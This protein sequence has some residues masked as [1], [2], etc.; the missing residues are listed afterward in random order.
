MVSATMCFGKGHPWR[1]RKT[2]GSPSSARARS[3][4]KPPST[5]VSST[6]G[7][8]LRTR[9]GRRAPAAVGP[10][11]PLQPLR[12]ER[13]AAGP[14]GA[15]LPTTPST[16]SPATRIASPAGSTS[17][18]IWSRS[19]RARRCRDCIRTET[20]IVLQSAGAACSRTTRRATASAAS[21]LSVSCSA[22]EGQGTHRGG[23]HRPRL[24]RHLRPAPLAGRRRHP[25]GGRARRRAAH[26]LSA[27]TTS[28]ATRK[29]HYAGKNV[30]VVGGG[31]SA[32][33]T[34]C[35]LADAGRAARRHLGHLA[36]PHTRHAADQRIAERPA[37]R[38]RPPGRAG[39]HAR[40]PRR[41]QRRVPRARPSS[42][43]SSR[44]A[45][46][47][48][49][50]STPACRQEPADLGG[51]PRHRQRRLHAG[52][53]PL[54]RAASPRM[55]RVARPDEAGGRRCSSTPATTA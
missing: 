9:P 30:L 11:P 27:S 46:T 26:R 31:Y 49:F 25:G 4:W 39:Q 21:S 41:R 28:S 24:H 47:R 45:P 42:T 14:A 44:S 2:G 52:Q 50:A 10:R 12:H 16:N 54:P 40:H 7:H 51:R 34:V 8:G 15:S 5:P 43:P 32:A 18:P 19:P 20:Q 13:H 37:P 35:N 3:G 53:R 6:S 23:R 1:K 36:G 33:T 55:L 17:P 38:A 29:S 22:R 48:V